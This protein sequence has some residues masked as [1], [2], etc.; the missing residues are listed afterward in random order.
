[1]P[2]KLPSP[3]EPSRG[4]PK[5]YDNRSNNYDFRSKGEDDMNRPMIAAATAF[6]LVISLTG[7]ASA[8]PITFPPEIS[9]P[10]QN[11]TLSTSGKLDF[12]SRSK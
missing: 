10:D 3:L 6:A 7:A 11:T 2:K 1:M 8:T 5:Y 12:G 9:V 4:N